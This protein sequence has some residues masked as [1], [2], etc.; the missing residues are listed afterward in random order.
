EIYRVSTAVSLGY[1]LICISKVLLTTDLN[2]RAQLV[3]LLAQ[4]AWESSPSPALTAQNSFLRRPRTPFSLGVSIPHEWPGKQN[5]RYDGGGDNDKRRCRTVLH[6]AAGR[7]LVDEGRKCIEAE[8]AQQDCRRKLLHRVH[9][10]Q[11]AGRENG[12]FE[13]RQKHRDG[14]R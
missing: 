6:R 9:E 8:W 10:H 5:D 13:Q 14:C 11:D 3:G 12:R 7:V 4:Q 1:E 2:S